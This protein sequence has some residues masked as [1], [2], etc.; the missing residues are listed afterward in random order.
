MKYY[1]CKR[2]RLI[3]LLSKV[4]LSITLPKV[5]LIRINPKLGCVLKLPVSKLN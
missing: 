3:H 5:T 2:E 4:E 1:R